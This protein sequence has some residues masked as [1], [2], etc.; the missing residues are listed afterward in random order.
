LQKR[1]Y[2]TCGMKTVK[3]VRVRNKNCKISAFW[4]EMFWASF[5][6]AVMNVL[7]AVFVHSIFYCKRR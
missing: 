3:K 2:A 4:E 7:N 1:G 5:R 6:H